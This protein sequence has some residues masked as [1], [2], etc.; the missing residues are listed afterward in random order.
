MY[1]LHRILFFCLLFN[2]GIACLSPLYASTYASTGKQDLQ[3][4][5]NTAI[6][7]FTYFH[8]SDDESAESTPVNVFESHLKILRSGGYDTMSLEALQNYFKNEAKT[9]Q[10][11]ENGKTVFVTFDG[12]SPSFQDNVLPLI[13]KY[14]IP[15]TVFISPSLQEKGML[16]ALEKHPL[17]DFGLRIVYPSD[18][19]LET[20]KTMLNKNITAYRQLF[21]KNPAFFAYPYGRH[22]DD[23]RQVLK[24]S[25]FQGAFHHRSGVMHIG[26]DLFSIPRFSMAGN[27]G[28]IDRFLLTA[29]SLPL[30]LYDVIKPDFISKTPGFGFDLHP[31]LFKDKETMN[32]FSS[33]AS[34]L[35]FEKIGETRI[36][37]RFL[38]KPYE[39]KIRVNCTMPVSDDDDILKWRWNGFLFYQ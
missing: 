19:S 3:D 24:N 12:L 37:I 26:E 30:P 27:F 4:I 35:A 32:C 8:I 15:V 17:I 25:G 6:V 21:Q 33:S 1:K 16:A 20:F 22:R 36:E 18:V 11:D 2:F 39:E 13:E 31:A 14:D 5:D 23:I 29:D 10:K 9:N 34:G 7:V 38:E 28:N